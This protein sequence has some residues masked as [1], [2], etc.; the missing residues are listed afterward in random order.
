MFPVHIVRD[1]HEVTFLAKRLSYKGGVTLNVKLFDYQVRIA[2]LFLEAL[3]Y[4]DYRGQVRWYPWG[5]TLLKD[6]YHRQY[7][8]STE[9]QYFRSRIGFHPRSARSPQSLSG[10]H[11][12]HRLCSFNLSIHKF[13]PSGLEE[14]LTIN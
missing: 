12:A 7:P 4:S 2:H 13:Y 1:S 9:N 11:F 3:N 8:T 5:W 14:L 6:L 10:R